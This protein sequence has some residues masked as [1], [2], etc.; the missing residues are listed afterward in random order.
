[1]SSSELV[2]LTAGVGASAATS[3]TITGYIT[4]FVVDPYAGQQNV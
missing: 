3:G 4:Y 1:M 2:Y